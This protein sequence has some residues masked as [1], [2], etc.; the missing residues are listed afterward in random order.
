MT[1]QP[2]NQLVEALAQPDSLEVPRFEKA[3]QAKFTQTQKNEYWTFYEFKLPGGPFEHGQFRLSSDG[4]KALLGLWPDPAKAPS[5]DELD[6]APWGMVT[7]ID[8]NPAIRPE[9][10]DAY[11]YNASGVRVSFQFHHVSR[12]LRSIAIEWGASPPA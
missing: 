3:L 12:K 1:K 10:A 11:I 7:N 9:G 8:I 6:L 4:S 5:E 2:I